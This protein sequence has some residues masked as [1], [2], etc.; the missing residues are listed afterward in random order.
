MTNR[1]VHKELYTMTKWDLFPS[2]R[3]QF[4]TKKKKK[5]K[6]QAMLLTISSGSTEAKEAFWGENPNNPK[7]HPDQKVKNNLYSQIK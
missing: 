2:M 1:T 6:N 7:K 3:E 5:K 4:T